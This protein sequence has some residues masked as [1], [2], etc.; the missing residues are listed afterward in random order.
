MMSGNAI[1][2]GMGLTLILAMASQLA[3][4][5]L[6]VPGI[7]LLLP[8][9]FLAGHFIPSVN[10][11]ATFGDTYKPKV[12]RSRLA[13]STKKT[14]HQQCFQS[15]KAIR[16]GP[17][18]FSTSFDHAPGTDSPRFGLVWRRR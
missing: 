7:V 15:H 2:F 10:L 1:I 5:K 18:S 9:G 12:A 3:A 6:R 4:L 14:G 11:R 16:T 17:D 13:R 8:I